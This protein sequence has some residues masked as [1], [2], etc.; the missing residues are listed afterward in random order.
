MGHRSILLV[1]DDETRNRAL[2]RGFL[3]AQYEVIE[4]SSG[5][6][7]VEAVRRSPVDLVLLDV[8]MPDQDGFSVCREL[9]GIV[10][11]LFLPVLLVTALGEQDDR[12]RGLEAGADDFLHKPVDRRELLLRVRSFLR[13]R[14]QEALIRAQVDELRRLQSL[15]D[16]L[17]SLLI[18]DLRNPLAAMLSTLQL[19]LDASRDVQQREDLRRSMKSAETLRERLDETLQVRLL[20]E[21]A[22]VAHRASTDVTALVRE[23]IDSVD[24]IARRR[25]INVRW[26]MEGNSIVPL[27]EK[28]VR[29]SLENL[30]SNALKY[31]AP[32]SEILVE[33]R[34]HEGDIEIEV[35]DR[36]PG[37]PD[38][39][40]GVLFQRFGSV[41]AYRG[42]QRR[43][44]GLGLYLV[45]LVAEAHC[46]DVSVHDREGGG[47]VF[48]MRLGAPA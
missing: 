25:G 37:I 29:R 17:V 46:G 47:T 26:T 3:G 44:T 5:R 6:E 16:D 1:V 10:D 35:A 32:E 41:E 36:G 30:L 4:A 48:R 40:K 19:A 27:D 21:N 18:H 7:A 8:M 24:T 9:K 28:L 20:E 42:R 2:L 43:G 33:V 34:N 12:N 39:L 11:D 22:L 45:K 31:T 15:E 13:L 23:C 38:P 14:H